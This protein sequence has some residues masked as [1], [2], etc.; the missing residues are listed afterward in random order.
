MSVKKR[1]AYLGCLTPGGGGGGGAYTL[2]A[3]NVNMNVCHFYTCF[4]RKSNSMPQNSK[5]ADA[6]TLK[7]GH[8]SFLCIRSFL[9]ITN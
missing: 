3:N 9:S 1:Q 6:I 7:L 4:P 8:F 5:T 2:L